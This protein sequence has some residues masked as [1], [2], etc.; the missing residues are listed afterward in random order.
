MNSDSD[1]GSEQGGQLGEGRQDSVLSTKNH[2]KLKISAAAA[3][4]HSAE[5]VTSGD[6][7]GHRLHPSIICVHGMFSGY[8]LGR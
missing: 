4:K 7:P 2:C 6:S 5:E 3:E 8:R 1:P